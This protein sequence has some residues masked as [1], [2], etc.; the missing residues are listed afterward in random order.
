MRNAFSLFFNIKYIVIFIQLTKENV[1]ACSFEI[2]KELLPNKL[3][4]VVH[5]SVKI[6]S[7]N[8]SN[9]ILMFGER[10]MFYKDH[11]PICNGLFV[12]NSTNI[13]CSSQKW[14]ISIKFQKNVELNGEQYNSYVIIFLLKNISLLEDSGHYK[15]KL[16]RS[17]CSFDVNFIDRVSSDPMIWSNKDRKTL[18]LCDVTANKTEKHDYFW[19]NDHLDKIQCRISQAGNQNC[20]MQK[21]DLN[22][23]D[24]YYTETHNFYTFGLFINEHS[25]YSLN[26]MTTRYNQHKH[27]H[28][29]IIKENDS[30][31]NT[32]TFMGMTISAMICAILLLFSI[33]IVRKNWHKKIQKKLT[34][35]FKNLKELSMN[36]N[37]SNRLS[38]SSYISTSGESSNDENEMDNI[39]TYT[40]SSHY[41]NLKR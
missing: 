26:D 12:F 23:N 30:I 4:K 7:F 21:F 37:Q 28:I 13:I 10:L 20:F 25:Q 14:S 8:S 40:D 3:F 6:F 27:C 11:E 29:S 2:S 19:K 9:N 32:I 41:S 36:K 38:D 22:L 16:G 31:V 34:R 35:R 17:K 1:G 15:L 18:V 39:V 5:S 33:L 24:Q